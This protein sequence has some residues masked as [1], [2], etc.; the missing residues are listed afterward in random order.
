MSL[1]LPQL[2]IIM[3][4]DIVIVIVLGGLIIALKV[5]CFCP[6]F[7]ILL[8]SLL[9]VSLF[10]FPCIIDSRYCVLPLFLPSFLCLAF[11]SSFP[12]N[13]SF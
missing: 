2:V 7:C 3:K 10:I 13:F 4:N 1:K 8:C 12:P 5:F 11:P 9:N 6:F